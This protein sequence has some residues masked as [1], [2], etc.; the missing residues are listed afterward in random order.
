MFHEIEAR[1]KTLC[2]LHRENSD[3]Q[4]RGRGHGRYSSTVPHINIFRIDIFT[5]SW[6]RV[7]V[8]HRRISEHLLALACNILLLLLLLLDGAE[9]MF[10]VH[11]V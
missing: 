5:D 1:K 6:T 10:S 4:G 11:I 3:V 9:D 2:I 8:L 7:F